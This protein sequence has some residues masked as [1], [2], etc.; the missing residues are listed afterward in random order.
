VRLYPIRHPKPLVASDV[1]YGSSDLAVAADEYARVLVDLLP[2]LPKAVPLYSSPL[3]RC[4]ELAQR[5]GPALACSLLIHDARLAEMHFGDWELR[6]WSTIAR[7]EIDAWAADP[8]VYRPGGGE[9]VLQMAQRVRAFHD[10]LMLLRQE[11]A[12]VVCH[13]GTIRMLLACQR[14]L[15][16]TETALYAVQTPHTISYGESIILD[17]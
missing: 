2:D 12:I 16:L 6:A 5:L 1:C 17:C 9:S 11:C 8:A 13:A 14:G 10:D 15:S 3:Q 7:A 4:A